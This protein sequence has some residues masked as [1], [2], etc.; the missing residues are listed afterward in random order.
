MLIG[1][2]EDLV[3]VSRSKVPGQD[4]QEWEQENSC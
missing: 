4:L 2:V 1:D 3:E